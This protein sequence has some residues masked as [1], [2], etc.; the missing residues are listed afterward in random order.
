MTYTTMS[1]LKLPLHIAQLNMKN[2]RK[3]K[4]SLKLISYTTLKANSLITKQELK[5]INVASKIFGN[6]YTKISTHS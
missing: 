3:K 6:L 2:R 5:V 4:I 1:L